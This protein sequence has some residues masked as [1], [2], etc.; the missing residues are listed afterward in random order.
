MA[1]AV[2]PARG[3]EGEPTTHVCPR[4]ASK[5]KT[6]GRAMA[7]AMAVSVSSRRRRFATHS[8]LVPVAGASSTASRLAQ[9]SG[10]TTRA[11]T[12]SIDT[13]APGRGVSASSRCWST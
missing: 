12:G 3:A 10:D 9:L 8:T 4:R 1:F 7:A 5:A 6:S 11:P 13:A 2:A